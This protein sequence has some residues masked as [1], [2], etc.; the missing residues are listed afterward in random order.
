[1]PT[2]YD[3]DQITSVSLS[4]VLLPLS[5]TV[6]DAKVITGR[7]NPLKDIA[8]LFAE[9]KTAQGFEGMGFSYALRVGGEGQF[10]HAG[11]IAP[12][13]IGEDPNNISKIWDKLLWTGASV[14]RSGIAVQ[15]IAAIDIALWDLKAKRAGLPL[16]R[17]IGAHRESV[18][19]Y[20]SSGGYLQAPIE[21]V[22]ESA[23]RS[24]ARG[25]GGVKL[26]VGQPDVTLDF[27]RVEFLRKH[28]GEEI[29]IM[30]D[31]NQ[32]WDRTTAKRFCRSMEQFNLVWIEEPLNAY[33][34]DGHAALTASSDTPIATGEMLSS[35]F[36][37]SALIDKRAV[38]IIQPD[39]PRLGGI[40]PFLRLA[41]MA[42][43]AGLNMAPHFVMEIHIH[44]AA[45]YPSETWVEHFEWLEP[46]FDE[47][48]DIRSGRMVVPDRNGLGFTVSDRMRQCTVESITFDRKS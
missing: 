48:L 25:I 30:I 43:D 32:Q 47:R 14:G 41:E 15:A 36:E 6:S 12:Y 22:H 46:L 31:A 28:L 39:A 8:L 37:Q 44:L 16:S 3:N 38:D 10:A 40:T 33:D 34:I 45:C 11:E 24:L 2:T 18:A 29:P 27:K 17:L 26:K 9:I 1:M 42:H 4:K 5:H 35:I 20:N 7:Q 19:C 13:I 23:Q 21:E